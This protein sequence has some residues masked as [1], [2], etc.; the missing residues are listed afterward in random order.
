MAKTRAFGRIGEL[1]KQARL[2]IDEREREAIKA[3]D[4]A[5]S[6][7]EVRQIMR[8]VAIGDDTGDWNDE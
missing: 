4:G 8:F 5:K 2:L 3:V 6:V 1:A 7:K